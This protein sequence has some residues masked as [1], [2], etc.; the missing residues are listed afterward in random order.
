MTF[1]RDHF[2]HTK[3]D[4]FIIRPRYM[5]THLS[6][7][8][9]QIRTSSHQLRIETRRYGF[10]P[11]A[12]CTC[13]LEP[14]TEEHYICRCPITMMLGAVFTTYSE[15]DLDRCLDGL[16]DQRCYRTLPMG[17]THTS[18]EAL[19]RDSPQRTDSELAYRLL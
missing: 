6:R 11:H 9:G 10:V 5:D 2:L 19:A 7:A 16:R 12:H 15:R 14:D 4:G 8:I 13:Q 3:V 1:Y 17:D 18:R